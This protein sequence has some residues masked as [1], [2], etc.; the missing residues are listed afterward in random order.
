MPSTTVSFCLYILQNNMKA[1]RE[2]QQKKEEEVKS[3]SADDSTSVETSIKKESTVSDKAPS[4]DSQD[5]KGKSECVRDGDLWKLLCRELEITEEQNAKIVGSYDELL[6]IISK[7]HNTASLLEQLDKGLKD[8][9]D[10]LDAY[11]DKLQGILTP[12]QVVKYVLWVYCY[13]NNES[14]SSFIKSNKLDQIQKLIRSGDDKD[15]ESV[16]ELIP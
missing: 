16:S 8:K 1:V 14:L 10:S 11:I 15:L 5:T 4:V 6:S 12:M 7:F 9:N 13:T 2:K 3:P